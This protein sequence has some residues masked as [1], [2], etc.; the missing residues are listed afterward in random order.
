MDTAIAKRLSGRASD[1]A[2]RN[3]DNLCAFRERSYSK[4]YGGVIT[5][6]V[7]KLLNTTEK[8]VL[9]NVHAVDHATKIFEM[10]LF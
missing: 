1:T 9:V 6:K 4:F 7:A 5:A 10:Q 3:P 2:K 8:H